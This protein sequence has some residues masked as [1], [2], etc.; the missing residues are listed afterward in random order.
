MSR[1]PYLVFFVG[2]ILLIIASLVISG[3][4]TPTLAQDGG[5]EPT[6]NPVGE[7]P[8][9]LTDIY[10]DWVH[11]PHADVEAEAFIH[12][13]ED[14]EVSERCAQCH[15]TPGYQDY[16]GA[17]G[18]EFGVDGP[19]P[20]GS[21]INCDACHNAEATHLD[22]VTFPSGIEVTDLGDS[23]RCMVCHQGR[24]WGGTVD[25]ALEE[26]AIE[27]MNTVSADLGF[28]NIHYYAA[29]ASLYGSDV[30]GGYQFEG[31]NYQ[32]QFQHAEGYGE[33]ED[34]HQPHTLEVKVNECAACHEDVDELEDIYDIRMQGSMIDYDGDGDTREGIK[35]EIETLQG[36][37]YDTMV[38]YSTEVVGTTIIYDSHAYPYFFTDL[39]SDGEIDEDEANYGNKYASF[40]GNL[41]KAAYNYQV[42]LKDPGAFAHNAKYH[43]E[44]LYDSIM[45]LNAELAEPMDLAMLNRD[46]PGHFNSTGEPFRHWD[47]DGE[48][49]ATCAKC[50]TSEGIPNLVHLGTS[51]P[52]EP[53]DALACSTC[54]NN[55]GVDNYTLYTFDEIEMP[56]GAVVSFGE[57]AES[58][59]CLNC[60]QGRESG[61]GI[62]GYI[63]A[64]GVGDDEVSEA[65]RFRN[66]HYFAAGATLFG[67]EANGAYQYEGMDY[68]GYFE[69]ERR[70]N[71]CSECH[72]EHALTIRSNT[73]TECH[74][75]VQSQA[76]VPNIRLEDE[77]EEA[78]DYDGDGDER[79]P[80]RM[81]IETMHE[82]LYA[83]IQDYA[84]N[85]IGTPVAFGTGY[86]YWFID[87]NGNG[88]VDEEEGIRDNA[89]NQWTPTLLRAIYN[90]TWVAK[91]PGAYAHNADYILQI[92]Y[93]ALLDM[94]GDE[95]VADYARPKPRY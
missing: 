9:F 28:I 16:L 57:E 47:E 32:K 94:G 75:E 56:S 31:D 52:V 33:C 50:H 83:N 74:E 66:P 95:A 48:V 19:A 93:D 71:E 79:E 81:E 29:A 24:S 63:S 84:A 80:I 36:I 12:W 35:G 55:I 4:Q 68:S 65:L 88:V 92:M 60:H 59:V 53:S 38:A 23:A 86:P 73:C 37:L 72:N 41:L 51:I 58:N 1:K 49:R 15:S 22:T 2:G 61:V 26:L 43:I 78:I 3:G 30:E 14:G 69:H 39:D 64:A 40:S 17:D 85:T 44:L 5:D 77:D 54:H 62:A 82:A 6:P 90:Y 25:A 27:D 70:F 87:T 20:L 46:D 18:T 11:S 76:D 10:E 34:C 67:S 42:S 7:P 45:V 89:Y 13:D 21:V 8:T 91:D